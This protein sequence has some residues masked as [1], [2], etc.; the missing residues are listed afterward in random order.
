MTSMRIPMIEGVIRRRILVN[1]RVDAEVAARMVPEPFRP[2]L[3]HGHAI[4]GVCLIRLEDIRP[5]LVPRAFGVSSENAAHRI[6]VEWDEDGVTH[7]GVY[8]PRRDSSSLVNHVLGGRVFSGEH[9]RARFRVEDD[10]VNITLHMVARDGGVEVEVA[11]RPA[12]ELPPT[13]VFRSVAEASAFFERGSLG[14]SATHDRQRFDGLVLVTNQWKVAPLA[15]V[16]A[17]SSFFEDERLFP[18]GSAKL[19]HALIMRDI[20]HAW[21]SAPDLRRV[22]ALRPACA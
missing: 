18:P 2:K 5:R 14:Y 20:E 13:S 19:D 6:A 7:E 22:A 3:H 1:Y 16:T 11:A 10:G 21:V 15:V 17:R 9:H 8:V 12:Q 4:A